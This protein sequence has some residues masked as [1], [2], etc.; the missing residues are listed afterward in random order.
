VILYV[1]GKRTPVL[2]DS[3]I[4][5]IYSEE[6][7]KY[8]PFSSTAFEEEIWAILIEK[9]WAKLHGS[10][11]RIERGS[12]SNALFALTGKPSWKHLHSTS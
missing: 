1:N 10:Y 8:V 4:P 2:I 5:T 3:L 6:K 9:A 7:K 11:Q 12:P